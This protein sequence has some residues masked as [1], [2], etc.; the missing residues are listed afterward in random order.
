MIR[1]FSAMAGI[2]AGVAGLTALAILA[3]ECVL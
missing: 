1:F 3:A 2:V